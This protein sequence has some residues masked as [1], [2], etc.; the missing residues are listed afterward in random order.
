[1]RA[2]VSLWTSLSHSFVTRS[3]V[4]DFDIVCP[5]RGT[6]RRYVLLLHFSETTRR[7]SFPYLFVATAFYSDHVGHHGSCVGAFRGQRGR[8]GR[9]RCNAHFLLFG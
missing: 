1:M 3:V 5:R 6:W 2:R 4:G 9:C 8:I 7:I